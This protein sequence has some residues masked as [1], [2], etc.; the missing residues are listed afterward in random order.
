MKLLPEFIS[1]SQP[2]ASFSGIKAASCRLSAC[3][4]PMIFE[5]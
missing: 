2:A 1:A 4:S 3:L 5:G